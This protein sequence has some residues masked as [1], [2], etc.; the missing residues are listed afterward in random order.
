MGVDD[1]LAKLI[2][3]EPD[4][5]ALKEMVTKEKVQHLMGKCYQKDAA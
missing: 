2:V 3:D 1:D 4:M 5:L